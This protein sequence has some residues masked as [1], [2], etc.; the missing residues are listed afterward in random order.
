MLK[1]IYLWLN[2]YYNSEAMAA[3]GASQGFL[4]E[5]DKYLEKNNQLHIQ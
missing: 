2:R 4:S 1:D 5:A 3:N